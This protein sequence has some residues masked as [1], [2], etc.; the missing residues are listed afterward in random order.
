ME[1]GNLI[2][3]GVV[4]SVVLLF[5]SVSVIPSSGTNVVERK[6]TMPTLYDRNTLYVGGSGPNN[7][8]KIQDAIDNASDGDTV[9]VYNGTY[10]E[11]LRIITD[12]DLFG[13]DIEKTVIDGGEEG[14]VVK[15]GAYVN[16][17]G[18]KIRNSVE[19]ITVLSLPPPNNIYKFNVSGNIIENCIIGISLGGSQNHIVYKNIIKD[20][21]LGI[22]F[23]CADNCEVKNNN[24]INN[25]KHAYFEY[26]LFFQFL[27]RIKW[28]GNFWDDWDIRI[29]RP[30]KG[31]KVIMFIF[32]P[33][34]GYKNPICPWINFDWR[35]AREPYDIGV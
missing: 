34:T 18:F 24:F 2:K 26:V 12:I 22:N 17:S 28:N 20:N 6:S 33:G 11:H 27:P 15:I 14:T 25:E 30:I 13:E 8:T 1:N 10:F 5:V 9:F 32:R 19:G 3:K 31:L 23:F 16:L 21:E 35:P 7:Y 4:V 29:P